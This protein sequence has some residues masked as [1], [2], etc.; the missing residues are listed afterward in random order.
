VSAVD[1]DS[2][3]GKEVKEN[4]KQEKSRKAAQNSF[5]RLS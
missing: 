1:F 2:T 4:E 5:L 3:A